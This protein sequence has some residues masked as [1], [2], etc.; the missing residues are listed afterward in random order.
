MA[1]YNFKGLYWNCVADTKDHAELSLREEQQAFLG[2]SRRQTKHIWRMDNLPWHPSKD[3]LH[4]WRTKLSP[5]SSR[6]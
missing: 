4:V 6:V 1:S 5:G 2:V 3:R